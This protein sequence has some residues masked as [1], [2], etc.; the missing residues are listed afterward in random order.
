MRDERYD[1][2][3]P[4][5]VPKL[6]LQYLTIGDFLWRSF[7]LYRAENFFGIRRDIEDSVVRLQPKL[8][9]PKMETQ[10]TGSSTMAL[11]ISKPSILEVAPPRVGEDRPAYVRAEI[12]INVGHLNDRARKEWE[13]LGPG[14]VIFL[15]NVRGYDEEEQRLRGLEGIKTEQTPAEKYGI[16]RLRSAEVIQVLDHDGRPLTKDVQFIKDDLA[17]P[18]YGR[19]VHVRIDPDAYLVDAENVK[20]G[21]PD[22]YESMNVLIRRKGMVRIHWRD[23]KYTLMRIGKQL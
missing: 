12:N 22:V 3:R 4:L 20:N 11:V 18:N 14:D 1:G 17:V 9:F 21:K 16:R 2:S 19:R 23:P 15:A 10:F 7:L 8:L 13:K 6:N 5:P